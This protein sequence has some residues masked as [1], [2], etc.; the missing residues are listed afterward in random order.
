MVCTFT[1]ITTDNA[2]TGTTIYYARGDASASYTFDTVI[3]T[4]EDCGWTAWT[5]T[6]DAPAGYTD[7]SQLG[8]SVDNTNDPATLEI[9]DYGTAS[10]PA[11]ETLTMT[12]YI[13]PD[14]NTS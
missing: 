6:L 12:F 5:T 7:I 14:E 3:S 8:L 2:I 9:A 13:I 4:T 11:T 10:G 1:T